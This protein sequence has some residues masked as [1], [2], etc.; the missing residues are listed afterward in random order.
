MNRKSTVLSNQIK[1]NVII[2]ACVFL[3][4][5]VSCMIAMKPTMNTAAKS[6]HETKNDWIYYD[7]CVQDLKSGNYTSVDMFG[8]E[9]DHSERVVCEP[10]EK[11]SKMIEEA[12]S[13]LREKYGKYKELDWDNFEEMQFKGCDFG[14]NIAGVA[15]LYD[16]DDNVIYYDSVG[17]LAKN[18]DRNIY[19]FVHELIH[20]L[21]PTSERTNIDE[22]LTAYLTNMAYPLDGSFTTYPFS[23]SIIMRYLKNHDIRGAIS[24]MRNGTL[25]TK[26]EED[27]GRPDVLKN[28]DDVYSALNSGMVNDDM[29]RVA[30]DI[31]IHYVANTGG[32][33]NEATAQIN[34]LFRFLGDTRENQEAMEYFSKVLDASIRRK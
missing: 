17:V 31:Y 34:W 3:V 4:I 23:T 16:G 27:I 11:V 14:E 22:G 21:A 25:I 2:V 10:D 13:I 12:R 32:I 19:T 28:T 18:D 30:I 29:A 1:R 26:V 9:S 6:L 24:D 7:A 8:E 15:A 5:V 20:V 33:D